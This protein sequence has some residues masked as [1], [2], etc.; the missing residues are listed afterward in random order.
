[1]KNFRFTFGVLPLKGRD[2][3]AAWG[4][5]LGI[6]VLRCAKAAGNASGNELLKSQP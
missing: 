1:M 3:F 5:M 4:P 6:S 2:A